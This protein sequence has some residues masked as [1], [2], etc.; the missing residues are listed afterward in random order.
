VEVFALL[1]LT[2][3]KDHRVQ[4]FSYP[5]DRPVLIREIGALVE[6]IGVR[7]NLL[8]FLKADPALGICPQPLALP[9]VKQESHTGIRVIP[10]VLKARQLRRWSLSMVERY[11]VKCLW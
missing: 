7:E 5:S 1:I 2:N 9:G 10:E 6:V 4:A 3:L 8:H 11:G